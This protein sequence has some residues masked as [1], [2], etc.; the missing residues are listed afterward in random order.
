MV[1]TDINGIKWRID[2]RTNFTSEGEFKEGHVQVSLSKSS[3]KITSDDD[4]STQKRYQ[5]ALLSNTDGTSS[6]ITFGYYINP[7]GRRSV[8]DSRV[9]SVQAVIGAGALLSGFQGVIK[10]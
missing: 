3:L 8:V 4:S 10:K 1:L 2:S 6:T 5:Y 9:N 7:K